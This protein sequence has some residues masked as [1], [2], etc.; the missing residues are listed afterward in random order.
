VKIALI[1]QFA[2]RDKQANIARGLENLEVAARNGARLACYAELAFEWFHP[3]HPAAGDVRGL[4]EPL[5]GP[6]VGAFRDKARELG[7]HFITL[8]K[9]A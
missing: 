5:D 3:Q 2:S 9:C 1:Q 8:V 4:A 7:Y 6:L